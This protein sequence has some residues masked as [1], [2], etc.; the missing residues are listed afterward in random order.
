MTL[1]PATGPSLCRSHALFKFRR[2]A[3][4][5]EGIVEEVVGEEPFGYPF[6]VRRFVFP[7]EKDRRLDGYFMAEYLA[8]AIVAGE[9]LAQDQARPLPLFLS[10]NGS[11]A[12]SSLD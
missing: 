11:L 8:L 4:L 12:W 3:V 5:K 2:A 10:V 9:E 6:A 1:N 7:I